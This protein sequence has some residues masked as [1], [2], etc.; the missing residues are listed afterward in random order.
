MGSECRDDDPDFAFAADKQDL[1]P[2]GGREKWYFQLV[3]VMTK[4]LFISN[5]KAEGLPKPKSTRP[6]HT[7]CSYLTLDA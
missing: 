6:G 5:E 7:T 1:F 2:I 3:G 4:Q